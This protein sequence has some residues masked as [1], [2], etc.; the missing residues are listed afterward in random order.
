MNT[1]DAIYAR[2]AVKQYDPTHELSAEEERTL[3]QA[4]M[5]SPTSFNMQHWRFVLVKDK[6]LRAQVREAAWG[7]PQITDASLLIVLTAEL[8]PWSQPDSHAARDMIISFYEGN[9]Q[10][11]R[12]EVM[13]SVGI[14]GQTLMLAAKAMGYDSC[15]MI[16][17]EADKV[18]RLI[19]LPA[20]HA[21][22]MIVVVGK[23]VQEP[24]PKRDKLTLDEVVVVDRFA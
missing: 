5:Q 6:A 1:L 24:T 8:R 10:L 23:A 11:Q 7:Q 21:I 17:F 19:N 14:A 4:A 15:P 16:G 9:P 18:A 12:D 13:R 3:L 2:R 22:G 20:D